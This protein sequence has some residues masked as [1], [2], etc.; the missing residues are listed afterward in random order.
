MI[1]FT[2]LVIFAFVLFVFGYG[3]S[4][5]YDWLTTPPVVDPSTGRPVGDHGS[6]E[7]AMIFALDVIDDSWER[8]AFLRAWRE[9]DLGEWPEF[10]P[11][12][13]AREEVHDRRR[14]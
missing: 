3:F 5:L 10:Y 6:H 11:W 8:D 7:N 12:L 4:R 14:V 13:K 2:S 1:D 9:G